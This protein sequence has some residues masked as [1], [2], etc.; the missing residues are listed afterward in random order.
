MSCLKFNVHV[1][2]CNGTGAMS[3]IVTDVFPWSMLNIIR[4]PCMPQPVYSYF[5]KRLR[6]FWKIVFLQFFNGVIKAFLN[7]CTNISCVCYRTTS[8]YFRKKGRFI[9]RRGKRGRDLN[10]LAT[11]LKPITWHH[12]RQFAAVCF[13]FQRL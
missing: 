11:V 5:G 7:N 8:F 12:L 2:V 9:C 3:S 1:F 13:L 6:F 4:N 10:I